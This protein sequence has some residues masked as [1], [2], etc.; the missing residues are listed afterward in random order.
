ML[1]TGASLL[2][3]FPRRLEQ[4]TC[5]LGG[6]IFWWRWKS[7]AWRN[8]RLVED[9]PAEAPAEVLAEPIAPL[10]MVEPRPLANEEE[11]QP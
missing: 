1:G 5:A 4:A 7:G 6:A 3:L 11:R 10:A 8:K 2:L 9:E